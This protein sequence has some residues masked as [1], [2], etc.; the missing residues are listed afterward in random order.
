[1]LRKIERKRDKEGKQ[2]ERYNLDCTSGII[3]SVVQ[4]QGGQVKDRICTSG[5]IR[6]GLVRILCWCE[7]Q[8][9]QI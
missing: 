2:G 8:R 9:W 3:R 4:T 1:M 7:S 5:M 6:R